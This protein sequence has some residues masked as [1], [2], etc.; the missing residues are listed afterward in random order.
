VQCA[1]H[2]YVI[3][4]HTKTHRGTCTGTIGQRRAS[5]RRGRGCQGWNASKLL[6]SRLGITALSNL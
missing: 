5:S 2:K 4:Q 3:I 1:K 6:P